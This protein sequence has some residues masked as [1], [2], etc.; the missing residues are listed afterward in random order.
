[1]DAIRNDSVPA[2]REALDGAW[3]E[4]LAAIGKSEG[5]WEDRILESEGPEDAWS[6]RLAA[7]H[8]VAGERIRA[9]YLRYLLSGGSEPVGDM[10]EYAASGRGEVTMAGL[11]EE[12]RA[13]KT[14]EQMRAAAEHSRAGSIE[15]LGNL[16]DADLAKPATNS[17]FVHGYLRERGQD[18]T[19]T[20]GGLLVHGVVHLRDHTEHILR[21]VS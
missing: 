4:F 13:V 3:E 15:L 19:D 14:P 20:V 9:S 7:W 11:R 18:P 8:V 17:T 6:P 10:M 5:R 21:S 12:F 2:L 1:M 16:S